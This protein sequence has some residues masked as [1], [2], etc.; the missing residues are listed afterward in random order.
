MHQAVARE[1]GVVGGDRTVDQPDN[2]IWRPRGQRHQLA[3]PYQ[4]DGVHR[5]AAVVSGAGSYIAAPIGR[6]P[7]AGAG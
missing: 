4:I 1:I 3:E 5:S 7:I 6:D 2:N